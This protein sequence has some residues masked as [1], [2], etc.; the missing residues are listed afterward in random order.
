MKDYGAIANTQQTIPSE[1][2]KAADDTYA[3]LDTINRTDCVDCAQSCI[4]YEQTSETSVVTSGDHGITLI[5]TTNTTIGV[6]FLLLAL[7]LH[8][9][10]EG[11][12]F[13]LLSSTTQVWSLFIAISIH[14]SVISFSLGFQIAEKFSSK[15]KGVFCFLLFGL[16]CLIGGI[17]GIMISTA[18]GTSLTSQVFSCVLQGVATGTFIH[19]IFFEILQDEI[20]NNGTLGKVLATFIGFV[21]MAIMTYFFPA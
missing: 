1:R 7:C 19:V 16:A 15:L 10:F 3:S 6:L 21:I 11:L 14:K 4:D 8:A 12:A 20:S 5:P 2:G 18:D 9:L 17:I 13:G